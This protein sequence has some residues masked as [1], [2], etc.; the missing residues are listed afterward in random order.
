MREARPVPCYP[1]EDVTSGVTP[2]TDPTTLGNH[3]EISRDISHLRYR[4]PGNLRIGEQPGR[5]AFQIRFSD[6][7]DLCR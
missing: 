5:S 3:H 4:K 7:E 1:D 6:S 2:T